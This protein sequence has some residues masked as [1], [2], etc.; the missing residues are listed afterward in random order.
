MLYIYFFLSY[1]V[2]GGK[3]KKNVLL[4]CLSLWP[5][6]SLEIDG[7]MSKNA[8]QTYGHNK[9]MAFKMENIVDQINIH[10]MIEDFVGLEPYYDEFRLKKT[11]IGELGYAGIDLHSFGNQNI[12][13]SNRSLKIATFTSKEAKSLRLELDVSQLEADDMVWILD[14]ESLYAFGPY[15]P[16][17]NPKPFWGPL[18]LGDTSIIV[19]ESKDDTFGQFQIR[20]YAHI[21]K[22]IKSDPGSSCNLDVNCQNK[23][24]QQISTSVARYTFIDGGAYLC[25]G[26]LINTNNESF[27]PY[28]LTAAHCISSQ[29]GASTIEVYWDYRSTFCGSNQGVNLNNPTEVPRTSGSTLL[30]TQPNPDSTLLQ[31]TDSAGD[32]WFAGWTTQRPIIGN[33]V[34]GIH[35][36]RGGFQRFSEGFL[37]NVDCSL[38]CFGDRCSGTSALN[39]TKQVE[40]EWTAS[41]TEGGSSGSPLFNSAGQIIGNE[42]GCGPAD[43][44]NNA[45]GNW[46]TYASFESF[47]PFIEEYISDLILIHTIESLDNQKQFE[48]FLVLYNNSPTTAMIRLIGSDGNDD[49]QISNF[50]IEPYSMYKIASKDL[51]SFKSNYQLDIYSNNSNIEQSQ[52][53]LNH[54]NG[55]ISI[56]PFG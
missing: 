26:T 7:A 42:T 47:A 50:S 43:C 24:I 31:L 14:S 6:L 30:V 33:P 10:F 23:D 32:R 38:N 11:Q 44:A 54:N 56:L 49:N 4:L 51:F 12:S 37:S 25:S 9:K 45:A 13:I 28:F 35:H 5:I 40:V 36:P 48:T 21:L 39:F 19:I 55:Y 20:N 41:L 1:N 17:D 18:V 8:M 29:T 46:D 53:N 22:S 2:Q 52:I 15:K 3:M 27:T 34:Y 16:Q